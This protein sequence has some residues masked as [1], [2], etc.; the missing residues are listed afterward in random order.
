MVCVYSAVQA[1]DG[2]GAG[3]GRTTSDGR[4]RNG[5]AQWDPS[6][7]MGARAVGVVCGGL[8]EE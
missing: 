3:N 6:G 7:S 4:R 5:T 8:V 1:V 2:T